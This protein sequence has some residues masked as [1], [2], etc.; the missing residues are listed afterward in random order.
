MVTYAITWFFL[1][2]SSDLLSLINTYMRERLSAQYMV[3]LATGETA[4]F[5]PH[6]VHYNIAVGPPTT[7][8]ELIHTTYASGFH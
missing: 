3:A 4:A 1:Q 5:R 6:H 8:Y 7:H 2:D